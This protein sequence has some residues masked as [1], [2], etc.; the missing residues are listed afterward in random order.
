[1]RVLLWRSASDHS[2]KPRAVICDQTVLTTL[3]RNRSQL[4]AHPWPTAPGSSISHTPCFQAGMFK[5]ETGSVHNAECPCE[6]HRRKLNDH[7][8]RQRPKGHLQGSCQWLTQGAY[9]RKLNPQ[10]LQ[11]I[12]RLLSCE[13][14]QEKWAFCSLVSVLQSLPGPVSYILIY[15]CVYLL[16]IMF[17]FIYYIY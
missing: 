2:R 16:Y 3:A 4:P 17:M 5:Q 7:L 6:Q 8:P 9:F 11:E 10:V 12:A 15:M 13:L 14:M 1:M